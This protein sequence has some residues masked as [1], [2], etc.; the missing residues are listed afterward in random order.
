MAE[1]KEFKSNT[2]N[3]DKFNVAEKTRVSQKPNE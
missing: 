3:K 2:D 1:A